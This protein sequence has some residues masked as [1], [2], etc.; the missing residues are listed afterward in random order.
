MQKESG[1][2]LVSIS[3]QIFPVSPAINDLVY[4]CP[5]LWC[6]NPK[7]TL[8]QGAN[9]FDFDLCLNPPQYACFCCALC[10]K[11]TAFL[12][13]FPNYT[14]RNPLWNE[15][16]CTEFV[17]VIIEN[18]LLHRSGDKSTLYN[19]AIKVSPLSLHIFIQ[20]RPFWF[21]VTW[22]P[23]TTSIFYPYILMRLG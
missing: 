21:A 11:V 23:L 22:C 8:F 5:N 17:N 10:G 15:Q 1:S 18:N 2:I 12:S 3:L 14:V 13:L 19:F 16:L 9:F 20:T 7:A 6:N 4:L